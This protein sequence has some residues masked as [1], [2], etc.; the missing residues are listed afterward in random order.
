MWLP[1]RSTD[2][3]LGMW[4]HL[5]AGTTRESGELFVLEEERT[6]SMGSQ[7]SLPHVI[8]ISI[9]S[10]FFLVLVHCS[11]PTRSHNMYSYFYLG[12]FVYHNLFSVWLH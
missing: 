11:F 8:G 2:L 3:D 5:G 4:P 1:S 7:Q 9:I 12:S 10:Y 6:K